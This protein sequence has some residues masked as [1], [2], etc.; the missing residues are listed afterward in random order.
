MAFTPEW[1]SV[2]ADWEYMLFNVKMERQWRHSAKGTYVV[3]NTRER[4]MIPLGSAGSNAV[5]RV[6]WAPTGHRLQ[7]VRDNNIFVTDMM[8]EI[9]IT[10]DGSDSVSNGV[11][12]WVYE[13]EVLGSSASGLWSPDGEAVAFL[14]LDD[15][16]VPVFQFQMFHPQN[17]SALY[18]EN[19]E[20]RYPSPGTPNPLVSLFVCRPDFGGASAQNSKASDNPDTRTHPQQISFESPFAPEDTIIVSMAWLTDHS[21]RLIV[22]VMNRVQ[23]HLKV[24]MVS[25][26]PK[27]LSGRLVRQRNTASAGGDGAWIEI[28]SPPIYVPPNTVANLT[29]DGYLEVVENGEYMH[30]ALFSPPEAAQPVRWLTSGNYDVV[31]NRVALDRKAALVR[32]LSTQQSSIQP[33]LYQ[34]ALNSNSTGAVPH[35]L[36]PPTLKS[37]SARLNARGARHGSYDASFSAGA[38]FYM[39]SYKGPR[40]PW[41]AVYSSAD[42][43]FEF[44][45]NDNANAEHEL[46]AFNLPT[47]EFFEIANDAGDMMNAMAMYPPD[48]DRSARKKY[49]VL[50]FVYGGPNS[51]HVSQAFSLDWMGA[52]V[53]QQDVPGMQWIVVRVDARGTGHKGRRFRSAVN[54]RLGVIE[55]ADQAAAARHFQTLPYVNPHRIAIWGWSYGGYV[56]ARAV[57]HHSDVFRVGMAVAPVSD[58]R[59][60]D[61]I[62]TERYMK[63]PLMN[64][65]GYAASAV[66]NVSGFAGARFLVQHGTAD[67]NVHMKNTLALT[68]L[69]QTNNVPGFE[70]ALYADSDHSI[71]TYG[72]RPALYARMVNFLF[73]S[74][75]EL[76][77]SEFSYWAHTDPND[78]ASS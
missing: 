20:V 35:A 70:M 17:R 76:E 13:E 64:P 27:Q 34:V 14:R 55:P 53:S 66:S 39:L 8:R 54:R 26:N 5:Q 51:Q 16:K 25:T 57:E 49:G 28:P 50:F 33:A 69:L 18:P 21:D 65:D 36:S 45:L 67:D 43:G 3:Y 22:H 58:W 1:W 12:D 4:T 23:D 61:S 2:S 32:F 31:S 75:H 56:T 62:Y 46:A 59:F 71:Y 72:V 29:T 9:Q 7:F 63:T 10:E 73:R 44:V 60:Y 74:F 19:I 68:T 37:A 6:E 11:A 24:Y 38:S 30:L 48:F 40:L 52:L 47:T 15:T 77:N 42:P 78:D 41:Q